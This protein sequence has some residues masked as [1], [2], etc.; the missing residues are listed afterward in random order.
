L[1][2]SLEKAG[3]SEIRLG[4]NAAPTWLARLLGLGAIH[5]PLSSVRLLFSD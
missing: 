4:H 1:T 2:L 5:L 3:K